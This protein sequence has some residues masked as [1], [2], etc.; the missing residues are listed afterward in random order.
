M[1]ALQQG[2][3]LR[4]VPQ[5]VSREGHVLSQAKILL[6][7]LSRTPLQ[8]ARAAE[9]SARDCTVADR[10][11][12][13]AVSQLRHKGSGARGSLRINLQVA[14]NIVCSSHRLIVSQADVVNG[15]VLVKVDE[16]ELAGRSTRQPRAEDQ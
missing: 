2:L 3:W 6:S 4:T 8:A 1:P 12:A 11:F 14:V 15:S 9:A 10:A 13:S 5:R 16:L 7:P